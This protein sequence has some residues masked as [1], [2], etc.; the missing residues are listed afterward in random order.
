MAL[1]GDQD[2]TVMR[3][4]EEE[5]YSLTGQDCEYY[6]LIRGSN[7]DPLYN[8]PY[9]D[10]STGALGEQFRLNFTFIGA[11]TYQERDN[12]DPA[13]RDEG[14]YAEY[15]AELYV[16]IN[17]WEKT[18]GTEFQPKEGDVIYGMGLFF[19]VVKKGTGGNIIDTVKYVG[20]QLMLKRRTKFV[21][22]RKQNM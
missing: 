15:D 19:D 3:R 7:V 21:P 18:A 14:F 22:E 17:E 20:Y 13:V 2:K 16:A 5:R 12:R 4:W 6:S 11:I 1:Y 10:T 8:E 9:P